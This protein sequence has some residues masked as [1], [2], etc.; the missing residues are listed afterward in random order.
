MMVTRRSFIGMLSALGIGTALGSM[1][2]KLRRVTIMM[3]FTTLALQQPGYCPYTQ[4]LRDQ[5]SRG[6]QAKEEQKRTAWPVPDYDQHRHRGRSSEGSEPYQQQHNQPERCT[7]LT[8][9]DARGTRRQTY[10]P[11]TDRNKR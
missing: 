6:S 1:P 3:N 4:Q 5:R 8:E 11:Q 10:K 2:M 9:A 7:V